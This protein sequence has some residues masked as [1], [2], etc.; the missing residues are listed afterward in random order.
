MTTRVLTL[1]LV[2]IS[3]ALPSAAQ[4]GPTR[5][6]V[7]EETFQ[8]LAWMEGRWEGSGG[9]FDAF[10]EAFRVVNDSTLEQTTYDDAS[11]GE[12]DGRS[13]MVLRDGGIVKLRDGAVES[14]VTR[15]SGDTLRFERVPPG[16]GGFSW[17]RVSDDEWRAVLDRPR[18]EPVVYTL[19]R[20][21]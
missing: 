6:P 4:D 11:F 8:G 17:I 9:G 12:P 18:G 2:A 15:L 5:G 13:I 3:T 21:P 14:V 20:I 19:R 16:R 10:Y 1:A 7:D